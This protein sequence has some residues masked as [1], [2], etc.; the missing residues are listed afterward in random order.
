MRNVY[1]IWTVSSGSDACKDTLPGLSQGAA[2]A[3]AVGLWEAVIPPQADVAKFL[4]QSSLHSCY[5]CLQHE[6]LAA[7]LVSTGWV[8]KS[9][10][11]YAPFRAWSHYRALKALQLT[12][13]YK[14]HY[15]A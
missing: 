4:V 14:D 1:D 7:A 13:P 9:P 12:Q 2:V 11:S 6:I 3:Q 8:P 15:L 5:V 10:L